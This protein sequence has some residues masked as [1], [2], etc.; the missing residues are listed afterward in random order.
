MNQDK[1]RRMLFKQMEWR[2][3]YEAEQ[4]TK[5][6]ITTIC[7][8]RYKSKGNQNAEAIKQ[9]LIELGNLEEIVIHH[10]ETGDLCFD[11]IYR[12]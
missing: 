7:N 6:I 2:K 9:S 8:R 11:S 1:F 10:T 12:K 4:Q 3:Q 5:H